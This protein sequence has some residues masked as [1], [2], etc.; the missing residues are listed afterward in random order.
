[1]M[2]PRLEFR[3][4]FHRSAK[5]NTRCNVTQQL[6]TVKLLRLYGDAYVFPVPANAAGIPDPLLLQP[7]QLVEKQ[8]TADDVFPWR[9]K[10][11]LLLGFYKYVLMACQFF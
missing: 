9:I 6:I 8:M 10:E 2:R 1:M 3:S 7:P 11:M 5:R 4:L